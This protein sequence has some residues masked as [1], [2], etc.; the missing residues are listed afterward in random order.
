[1]VLRQWRRRHHRRKEE[2]R[3]AWRNGYETSVHAVSPSIA[4]Q[5]LDRIETRRAS[6]RIT[7]RQ[8]A[9]HDREPDG[10]ADQPERQREEI[11]RRASL[12][13]DVDVRADVDDRYNIRLWQ[14]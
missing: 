3:R 6:L 14:R 9:H 11:P 12:L 5:R 2:H 1:M 4:P 13:L 7:P 8:Q 10:A